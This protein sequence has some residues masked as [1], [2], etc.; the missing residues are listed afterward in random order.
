[1]MSQL[2]PLALGRENQPFAVLSGPTFAKELVL[3]FPTGS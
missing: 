3:G 1:M 2:V